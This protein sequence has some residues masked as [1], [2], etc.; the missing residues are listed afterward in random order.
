MNNPTSKQIYQVIENFKK[1]LPL[2]TREDHLNM[3]CANICHVDTI[4]MV[5]VVLE[6]YKPFRKIFKK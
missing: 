5:Y 6:E 4:I 2:A 1:V 3:G